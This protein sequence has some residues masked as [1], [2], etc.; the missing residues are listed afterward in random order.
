MTA[1]NTEILKSISKGF[2]VIDRRTGEVITESHV[3]DALGVSDG[4][5]IME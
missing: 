5:M 1:T 4:E 2:T 3:S